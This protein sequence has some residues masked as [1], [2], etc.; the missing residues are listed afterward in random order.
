MATLSCSVT[1]PLYSGLLTWDFGLAIYLLR[2][3]IIQKMSLFIRSIP[4]CFILL[5]TG[6][7]YGLSPLFWS[8][9][10]GMLYAYAAANVYMLCGTCCCTYGS[11][12]S[13]IFFFFLFP[14]L[15]MVFFC[16]D[17]LYAISFCSVYILTPSNSPFL[18]F[19]ASHLVILI[20][21][22]YYCCPF[23]IH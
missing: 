3:S 16:V 12:R 7:Y 5:P 4:S 6:S 11:S 2:D 15:H 8:Y 1:P 17:I 10:L 19:T 22:P 20:F 14:L 18:F 23:L 13:V 21:R 9:C